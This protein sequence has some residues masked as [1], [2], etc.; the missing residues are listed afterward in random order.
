[1][2]GGLVVAAGSVALPAWGAGLAP[3]AVGI[4]D[5]VFGVGADDGALLAMNGWTGAVEHRMASPIDIV[6]FFANRSADRI[7]GVDTGTGRLAIFQ[8]PGNEGFVRDPII[9]EAVAAPDLFTFAPDGRHAVYADFGAGQLT[10]LDLH[11]GDAVRS[12]TGF[13][14]VHDIR[15][16]ALTGLLTATSLD[17]AAVRLLDTEDGETST[18]VTIPDPQG[19]GID[20]MSQTLSG[21]TGIIIQPG[22]SEI[23]FVN[24]GERGGELARS[25]RL[26]SPPLRAFISADNRYALLPSTQ[27][28]TVDVIDLLNLQHV[29]TLE[30]P[31]LIT[32]IQTDPISTHMVGIAPD[33]GSVVTFDSRTSTIVSVTPTD[34]QADMLALNEESGLAFIL[35][36]GGDRSPLVA[37]VRTPASAPRWAS[38]MIEQP[39]WTLTSTNALAVCH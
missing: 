4:A 38:A 18:L 37:P 9:H 5:F 7:I 31:G 35:G 1:M 19:R 22:I 29:K 32:T 27:T 13:N 30:T 16:S 3:R 36:N 33:P 11:T 12:F 14:G 20:H 28:P 15:F 8:N 6:S 25:I 26:D 10:L 17:S 24:V 2:L 23:F 21:R 34:G 39:M